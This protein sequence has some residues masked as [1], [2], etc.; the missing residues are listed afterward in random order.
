MITGYFVLPAE[1]AH[2]N[3][4]RIISADSFKVI[5]DKK[6]E[7]K[8]VKG[9]SKPEEIGLDPILI[10]ENDIEIGTEENIYPEL[11]IQAR[12]VATLDDGRK[13]SHCLIPEWTK[14]ITKP[15][16]DPEE[17]SDDLLTEKNKKYLGIDQKFLGY[18]L[19]E[20]F[21]KLPELEGQKQVGVDEEGNPV[22]VDKLMRLKWSGDI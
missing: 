8:E 21:A 5:K 19:E 11:T 4:A 9:K 1:D 12:I 6:K 18:T 2:K 10:I 14:E 3:K 22:M 20:V 17:V 7:I 15:F 13:V 16:Q